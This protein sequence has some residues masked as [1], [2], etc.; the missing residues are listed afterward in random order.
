VRASGQDWTPALEAELSAI[1][2]AGA[3]PADA[4]AAVVDWSRSSRLTSDPAK[5]RQYV[6][7]VCQL[8]GWYGLEVAGA[9]VARYPGVIRAP[10][11]DVR[12]SLRALLC[13]L[14]LP[15]DGA[16]TVCTRFPA[17]LTVSAATLRANFAALADTLGAERGPEYVRAV[18]RTAPLLLAMRP[19]TVRRK[20]EALLAHAAREPASAAAWRR[21]GRASPLPPSRPPPPPPPRPAGAWR[22]RRCGRAGPARRP[23]P[24]SRAA[25]ARSPPPTAAP[26]PPS[27]G[28]PR[29]RGAGEGSRSAAGGGSRR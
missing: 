4:A 16:M 21:G 5:L 29:P 12:A 15:P 23:R 10:P 7:N 19:E 26:S 3:L 11:D 24:H 8:Q 25:A 9:W 17:L 13:V 1:C 2:A 27:R 28:T 22:G 6:S 20:M 18:A 14:A